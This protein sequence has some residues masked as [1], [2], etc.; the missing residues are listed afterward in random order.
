MNW[1]DYCAVPLQYAPHLG[2]NWMSPWPSAVNYAAFSPLV[3]GLEEGMLLN[4]NHSSV[5]FTG[6]LDVL[7]VAVVCMCVK[8]VLNHSELMG[9]RRGRGRSRTPRRRN[10]RH[11]VSSLFDDSQ[12]DNYEVQS[13][14]VHL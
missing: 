3:A 4:N 14:W 6:M 2:M 8:C 7:L 12:G 1:S 9:R 11:A 13:A 5:K 10:P